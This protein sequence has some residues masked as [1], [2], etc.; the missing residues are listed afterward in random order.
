MLFYPTTVEEARSFLFDVNKIIE[1]NTQ[2]LQSGV[3]NLFADIAVTWG[4]HIYTEP[5]VIAA[6]SNAIEIICKK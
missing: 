1:L 6:T 3:H 5:E 4:K 2:N